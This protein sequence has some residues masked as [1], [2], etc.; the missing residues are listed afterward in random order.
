M[1][2]SANV[3]AHAN[4]SMSLADLCA[5]EEVIMATRYQENIAP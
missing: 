1:L 2:L 5:A 4:M 3:L